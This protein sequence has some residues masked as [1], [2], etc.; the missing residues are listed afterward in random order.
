MNVI[1]ES[2]ALIQFAAAVVKP[3]TESTPII[4]VVMSL[5]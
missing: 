5:L 2:I 3:T 1:V 4:P